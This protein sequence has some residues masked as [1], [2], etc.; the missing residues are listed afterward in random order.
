MATSGSCV[1]VFMGFTQAAGSTRVALGLDRS[2]RVIFASSSSDMVLS[3]VKMTEWQCP[4]KTCPF[5]RKVLAS[6]TLLALNWSV[7]PK[8][9][10]LIGCWKQEK[11]GQGVFKLVFVLDLQVLTKIKITNFL[12]LGVCKIRFL[13]QPWPWGRANISVS[14]NLYKLDNNLPLAN[15]SGQFAFLFWLTERV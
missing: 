15:L 1:T 6:S 9:R 10:L 14:W 7:W 11:P 3:L 13:Q 5:C 12:H 4:A 2:V 8:W